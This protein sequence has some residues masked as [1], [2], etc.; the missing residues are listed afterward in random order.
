MKLT[1]LKRL[2][3]AVFA[4]AQAT[5]DTAHQIVRDCRRMR[6]ELTYSTDELKQFTRQS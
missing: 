4:D 1:E 2:G 6:A 5:I 3:H